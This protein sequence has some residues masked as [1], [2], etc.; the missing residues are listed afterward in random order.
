VTLSSA[1]KQ[2]AKIAPSDVSERNLF[3]LPELASQDVPQV[4]ESLRCSTPGNCGEPAAQK[5]HNPLK[6][7]EARETEAAKRARRAVSGAIVLELERGVAFLLVP[8]FLSVGVV[9]YFSLQYEP[10]LTS[11]LVMTVLATGAVWLSRHRYS[12][13][14]CL[15]A[16]LLC[17]AGIWLSRLETGRLGTRIIG[18][19]IS[20]RLTG[21]VVEIEDMASGRKRLTLD[22]V[23]TERPKL[24]YQP[25]RVRLSAR[26]VSPDIG[27]GSDVTG[28]VRLLPPAGP[29]RPGS[30][31]T[32]FA[33]Y[34]SGIGASGFF[35]SGPELSSYTAAP[36]TA[37]IGAA[38][39][40]A[41]QSIAGRIRQ[42]VGG[43]EGEIAAALIVGVRAGIPEEINEAMR[44]TGIYHIISISGLHMA[45]VA[46]TVMGLM[47][48]LFALFPDFSSRRP[49]KK[50]AALAALLATVAYLLISGMVVAAVRS[51][52]MLAV[53]LIA[54]L[55]DRSAL[56]MRN[57][58]I[59]AII[60]IVVTPHEVVGPSFQMSFAATAALVG[61]Y[62]AWSDYRARRMSAPVP[63]RRSVAGTLLHRFL[64]M[65]LGLAATSIVA[66]V[67]T[68]L[69]AAWHFQRVAPLSL[70]ANL[71]VMP[72][73][74]II[75]MPFA[76]FAS[77]AMPLGLDGPFLYVMGQGLAVM[78]YLSER[79]ADMSPLDAVGLISATS[80][81]FAT[82]A[83]VV[84]TMATT[85]LRWVSLPFAIISLTTL[86]GVRAPDV[87]IS[88]DARLLAVAMKDGTIAVNRPRPNAFT[89]DN[90]GR[91]LDAQDVQPP[92]RLK[93]WNR[94][95]LPPKMK[96]ESNGAGAGTGFRCVDRVCV[97]RHPSGAQIVQA[98]DADSARAF[99]KTASLIVIEDATAR[100]PCRNAGAAVIT[101]RQLAQKGSAEVFL[102]P[103]SPP[104]AAASTGSMPEI[105]FSI[106][107]EYRPWHT[108]RRF[109]REA[110]GMPPY[111]RKTPASSANAQEKSIAN[112]AD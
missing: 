23:S 39:E 43:P 5:T 20:V 7:W 14:L 34:F 41:R 90:W 65:M 1:G 104:G 68:T 22:V 11:L 17:L 6:L 26:K 76:V 101:R 97:A 48:G 89:I 87:L 44:K 98:P 95:D 55:F 110:R 59:S 47:R 49:V 100:S 78:I 35:L 51:F 61:A 74:S 82:L 24:R 28:L 57:L 10:S 80:V 108:Q 96:G 19:E 29:I 103:G 109:S 72:V 45:L 46:G 91:A 86:A 99:C 93:Q 94:D 31:D 92:K 73:V 54:V 84:G 83:L 64:V 58:A 69:Y 37:R 2:G 79:I 66:G 62:A 3:A 102:S 111:E 33:A 18:S 16:L 112:E 4:R 40:R 63:V 107:G 71:A 70:L 81:L 60:V 56:T 9:A 30:Y 105:R 53:M 38:I 36:V 21:R 106:E 52:I 67:A 88:E 50:Y 42:S 25:E 15:L 8:V 13:Q 27:P 77:I 75:V 32:S 12:L 85:W